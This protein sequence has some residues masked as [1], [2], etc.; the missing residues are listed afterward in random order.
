MDENILVLRDVC[1]KGEVLALAGENGAGKSTLMKILSGSYTRDCGTIEFCGKPAEIHNPR[2]AERLGLSIIYQELNVL[3]GLSVAENI[4]I[5]RQ[6]KKKNGLVDWVKMNKDAEELFQ[7][8]H[9]GIQNEKER[10]RLAFLPALSLN[11]LSISIKKIESLAILHLHIS[12]Q[13]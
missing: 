8:L 2:D 1:K 5:G 4:F 13:K 3:Q 7:Q 6:P 9:I 11:I 12:L 10:I